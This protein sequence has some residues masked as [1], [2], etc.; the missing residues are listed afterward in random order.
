MKCCLPC[1]ESG[2]GAVCS[3]VWG[4]S[5]RQP[6]PTEAEGQGAGRALP[7]SLLHVN[8]SVLCIVH[9]FMH[10]HIHACIH[11]SVRPSVSR[12]AVALTSGKVPQVTEDVR[13]LQRDVE[14]QLV[15]FLNHLL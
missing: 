11:M 5:L 8:R 13:P 9:A 14:Q 12:K 15:T 4:A 10:S 7:S 6:H 3:R 2:S 1:T